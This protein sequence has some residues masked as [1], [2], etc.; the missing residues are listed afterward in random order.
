MN[1]KEIFKNQR[2]RIIICED[3]FMYVYVFV[4]VSVCICMTQVAKITLPHSKNLSG[5]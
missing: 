4:Y 3:T 5:L 2:S 1:S